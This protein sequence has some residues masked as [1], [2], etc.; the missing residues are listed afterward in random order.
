SCRR[1]SGM[2]ALT[3]RFRA[4]FWIVTLASAALTLVTLV[5]LL[6]LG[7]QSGQRQY[8]AL[9]AIA[10]AIL[11]AHGVAWLL[12]RRWSRFD[13]GSWLIAGSQIASAVLAPL[14]MADYWTIGPFLLAA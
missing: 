14:F 10:A 7:S 9:A 8:I 13:L 12:A 2:Q 1:G 6:V 5:T 4:P 11:L 3:A